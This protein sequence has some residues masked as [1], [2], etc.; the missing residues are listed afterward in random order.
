MDKPIAPASE[1]LSDH[2]Q[3]KREP[4]YDS[5]NLQQAES[6]LAEKIA[7]LPAGHPYAG[8]AKRNVY[9]FTPTEDERCARSPQCPL[10]TGIH[11]EGAMT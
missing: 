5:L 11:D 6:E 8:A 1:S 3:A 4:R 10:R 9:L 7:A 2:R